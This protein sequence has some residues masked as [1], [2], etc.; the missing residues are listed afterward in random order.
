MFI[1][2]VFL[3]VYLVKN[4]FMKG[5]RKY[6]YFDKNVYR[7]IIKIVGMGKLIFVYLIVMVVILDISILFLYVIKYVYFV[8]KLY[9][10]LF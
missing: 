4:R 8:Y 1:L 6:G 2:N 9:N 3:N 5:C 10:K 7:C